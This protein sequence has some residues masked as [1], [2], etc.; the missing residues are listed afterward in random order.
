MRVQPVNEQ[1]GLAGDLR[2][3]MKIEKLLG[4]RLGQWAGAVLL[5]GLLAA[6]GGGGSAGE[7]VLG[8][9]TG[10]TT[11]PAALA[12]LALV[13]DKTAI[14]N[15]G[16]EVVSFKVT[17]LAAGNVALIGVA[18]PVTVEVDTGAVVT[19]SAKVTDTANGTLTAVVSL[20]DKTSRTIKV[21]ATSGSIKKTVSFNVV[22]SVTGSAVADL[23]V[24]VDKQTIANT[25]LETASITVTSLD[26]SRSAIGGALVTMQVVDVGDAVV[27]D[28]GN[29]NT[30]A[31]SGQLTRRLS[32]QN[33]KTK[34]TIAVKATSGTVS[35]TI[36]V[37]VVDPPPGSVLLANDLSL[38]LSKFSVNDSGSESAEV[39]AKAVD[40]NRNALAGIDVVFK[41]DND[42]VFIPVNT[43]TDA[44]GEARGT[45]EIGS[46]RTVRTIQVSAESNG[47]NG[48][49]RVVRPLDVTGAKLV[50]SVNQ[51]NRLVGE[52]GTVDY[53]LVDVNG[54]PIPNVEIV[55][56]GPG[57]ASGRG[58]TSSQ[59]R[60]TYNYV[61][62]GSGK[63]SIKALGGAG[64][65]P[66]ESFV[67]VAAIPDAVPDST[68]I[69]SATMTMD[70]IVVKVNQVGQSAN[71][72]EIRLL[73]RGEKNAP[74]E[75]VRVRVGLGPN[76]TTTDGVLSVNESEAPLLS[77]R[78]GLVTLSFIPGQRS[79]PTDQVKIY[80][81]YGYNDNLGKTTDKDANGVSTPCANG[82]KSFAIPPVSLTV[83]ESPISIS[84]G[85][86][87]VLA[88]GDTKLTYVAKFTVL[89][90]DAA[91]NPQ[92][93][94]QIAPVVDLLGYAKGQYYYNE[95][96][97]KWLFTVD[98]MTLREKFLRC[99]NEDSLEPDGTRNGTIET[100][101]LI[102]EDING[103]GQL[104]PR[105]SDV[106][107][108]MV[109]STKT[110]KN[111]LATLRIEYPKSIASWVRYMVKVSA[112]GVLSPPAWYG[113]Y[114]ER[115]LPTLLT[116][117]KSETTPAFKLSP[118]GIDVTGYDDPLNRSTT[119][120]VVAGSGCF[121]KY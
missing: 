50:A 7:P 26:A 45:V 42:G 101:G 109:G 116:A 75:N 36:T 14:P 28:P 33:N 59:G 29:T 37:D 113:R 81:C 22:D 8:G 27:L 78:N 32:L 40:A 111:G 39:V 6:C 68:K 25:G 87:D 63:V 119:S 2:I 61:A 55:V 76:N 115:W 9:G 117:I 105:K 108:G 96:L 19:P 73:F 48:L 3:M 43:K 74:I 104:D 34:R 24:V 106:S 97:K 91:G 65:T 12:D 52:A 93:D 64:P 4:R 21:T 13:A 11:T 83:V 102:T 15:S 82:Q 62:Q 85:S 46:N 103:S 121:S 10:G 110:D 41:V 80:A 69:L 98:P 92:S 57:T 90:V 38:T 51:P 94:V 30:S 20:V 67:N 47:L 44:K 77:D 84:I 89:V 16:A 5:S 79:S 72:A 107:I 99:P 23:S 49:L 114:E 71:R 70:P 17:A 88:E 118:Y 35:R 53:S 58:T 60:W 18:T 1:A 66:T 86:D 31:S 120:N 95:T 56:T 112:P 54:S 100:N